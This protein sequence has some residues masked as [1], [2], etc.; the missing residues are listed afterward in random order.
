MNRIIPGLVLLIVILQL[1]GIQEAQF[2]HLGIILFY[3][4]VLSLSWIFSGKTPGRG[5]IITG[6]ALLLGPTLVIALGIDFF[7]GLSILGPKHALLTSLVLILAAIYGPKLVK[8][9][10]R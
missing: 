6:L 1:F 7:Y 8:K 2:I 4:T 3:L 5:E 10:K 9:S